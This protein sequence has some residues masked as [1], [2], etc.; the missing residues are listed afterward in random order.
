MVNFCKDEPKF[1]A[2]GDV[3]LEMQELK[4][5]SSPPPSFLARR[6]K[7]FSASQASEMD[8]EG[9]VSS[10]PSSSFKFPPPPPIFLADSPGKEEISLMKSTNVK[11]KLILF[12]ASLAL[13][14]NVGFGVFN[15]TVFYNNQSFDDTPEE[16]AWGELEAKVEI[17]LQ[18][19][20]ELRLLLKNLTSSPQI[21]STR[22][23]THRKI[24]SWGARP[25][26]TW[27]P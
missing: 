12:V 2:K 5:F 3:D 4:D 10:P 16:F 11:V 8:V 1:T 21:P 13:V 19:L 26:Y 9:A 27:A 24:S 18:A 15:V 7:G 25:K 22:N 17:S 14:A 20:D 23:T 6:P